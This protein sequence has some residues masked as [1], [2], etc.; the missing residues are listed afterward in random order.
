M[1]TPLPS[2]LF[3][4]FHASHVLVT[5]EQHVWHIPETAM[6]CLDTSLCLAKEQGRVRLVIAVTS[7]QLSVHACCAH[8]TAQSQMH[9]FN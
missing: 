8:T 3:P 2:C 5:N 1:N 9:K 4:L 6:D 7:I